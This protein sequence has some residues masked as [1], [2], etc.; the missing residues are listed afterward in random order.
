MGVKVMVQRCRD[1]QRQTVHL[2]RTSI[3]SSTLLT[4]KNVKRLL[5]LLL[6]L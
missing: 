1:R 6:L 3:L 4:F 5:L 2:N